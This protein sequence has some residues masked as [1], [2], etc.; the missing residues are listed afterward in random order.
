MRGA[1]AW[2]FAAL[3]ALTLAGCKPSP[4][5]ASPAFWQ[6]DGPHGERAWLLGTIHALARPA[7]WRGPAIAQALDQASVISVEVGNLDDAA[8]MASALTAL[9]RT[10]GQP[11]LSARV[12]PEL[13]PALAKL[14]ASAGLKD[15]GFGDTESW[16]AALTLARAGDASLDPQ[17]GIDRAILKARQR[18]PVLELE[19]ARGQLGLF[20]ALPEKEQR[21]LLAIIVRDGGSDGSASGS[22]AAAWR[23]GDM[24]AIEAETHRGLLADPELREALFAAR[25]RA[26]AAKIEALMRQGARPFVA[27]GAAHMAGSEGLPALLAERGF[28]VRRIQ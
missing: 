27:V 24:A 17:F 12:E 10:P 18:K 14:L 28:A 26:W 5:P 13:R 25:N 16:A 20:D 2:L 6:V 11:P 15:N 22:L 4:E 23:K 3:G 21:D 8:A 1:L 9:S 7:D 19:G